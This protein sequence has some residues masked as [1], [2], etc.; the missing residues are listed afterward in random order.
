MKR[1]PSSGA[2]ITVTVV[3]IRKCFRPNLIAFKIATKN[4]R[5]FA[6]KT[7]NKTTPTGTI[8]MIISKRISQ[9]KKL[10]ETILIAN[11]FA[12]RNV[13]TI[14]LNLLE[15][16]NITRSIVNNTVAV[17]LNFFCKPLI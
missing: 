7:K 6:S 1:I 13:T 2:K 15:I 9:T 11:I 5:N 3:S 12:A 4:I 17:I 8:K 10:S 16:E 14:A